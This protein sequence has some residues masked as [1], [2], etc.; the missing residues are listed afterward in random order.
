MYATSSPE[1]PPEDPLELYEFESCPY[2]RKVREVLTELDLEYISRTSATGSR[3]RPRVEQMGGQQ[4]FPF[5]VDPNTDLQMY[6]SEDIIDYLS[7]QYGDG[8]LPMARLASPLNTITAG[9]STL[10]RPRGGRIREGLDVREDPDKL[11]ELYNFEIS[12]FCRK[13][14]ETLCELDLDY[15][16]HNVGKGSPRREKLKDLGGKVQVPY[17]IDPNTGMDL[18]ESDDIVNYL[19]DVYGP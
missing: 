6:E 12:P 8:R 1:E 9:I 14:R 16:V 18:Y 19:E 13:V 11:L 7:E 15:H 10:V 2:C 17:I 4:Q 3:H 5:L